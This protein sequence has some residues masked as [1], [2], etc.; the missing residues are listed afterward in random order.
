MIDKINRVFAVLARVHAGTYLLVGGFSTALL[1]I[2]ILDTKTSIEWLRPIGYSGLFAKLIEFYIVRY[3][4]YERY[5]LGR[6]NLSVTNSGMV[7]KDEYFYTK[8]TSN[9]SYAKKLA[10]YLYVVLRTW[11]IIAIGFILFFLPLYWIKKGL[12]L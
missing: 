5:E 9:M 7:L 4:F 2:F 11:S 1:Y 10:G 12:G 6:K 8:I 3:F